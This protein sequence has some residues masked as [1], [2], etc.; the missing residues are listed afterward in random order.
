MTDYQSVKA[1]LDRAALMLDDM[2]QSMTTAGD[3]DLDEFNDILAHA[4]A[5]AVSLPFD[6][7]RLVRPALQALL[8]EL[9]GMKQQ[10]E[11]DA[12]SAAAES[13]AAEPADAG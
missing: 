6:D 12:K 2:R 8:D 13:A 10:L 5:A 3:F 7:V 1:E 4:C 11:A 9:E